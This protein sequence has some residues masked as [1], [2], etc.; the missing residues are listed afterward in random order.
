ML[1]PSAI[2][3]LTLP[4]VSLDLRSQL[5]TAPCIYFAVDSE[6]RVQYLLWNKNYG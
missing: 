4:S 5:P 2:N 1:N 3:P 6:G